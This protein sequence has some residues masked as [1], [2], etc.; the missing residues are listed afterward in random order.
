MGSRRLD[1]KSGKFGGSANLTDE[2]RDLEQEP[3]E[4]SQ[5]DL[6]DQLWAEADGR[7]MAECGA[8]LL[9]TVMP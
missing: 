6:I 9:G 3:Q 4:E 7:C 5:K 1:G 8:S 2:Q